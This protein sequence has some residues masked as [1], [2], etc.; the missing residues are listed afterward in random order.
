MGNG[1]VSMQ[2]AVVPMP[3]GLARWLAACLP[4]GLG[5]AHD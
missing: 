3:T 4:T 1:T 5:F 2:V